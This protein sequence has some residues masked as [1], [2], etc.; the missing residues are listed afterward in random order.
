M[1]DQVSHPYSKIASYVAQPADGS[2]TGQ[3][4]A[5]ALIFDFESQSEETGTEQYQVQVRLIDDGM[6]L[7]EFDVHMLEI[8]VPNKDGKEVIAKWRLLDTAF[9]NA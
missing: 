3:A 8:P 2:S 7:I 6:D 1:D 4:A 9:S 5:A